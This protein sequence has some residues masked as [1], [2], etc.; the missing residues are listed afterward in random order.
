VRGEYTDQAV[1]DKLADIMA[2]LGRKV[3]RVAKDVPGFLA[4]RIQHALM[5]EA[6]SVIDRI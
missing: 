3:I 6:F 2:G 5:R 4:N 1:C